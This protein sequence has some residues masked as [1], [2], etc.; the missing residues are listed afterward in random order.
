MDK[1][2]IQTALR[3]VLP[4]LPE[5][6][7]S[8]VA[9]HLVNDVGVVTTD[10]LKFVQPNDLPQLKPIQVRKLIQAWQ[11]E[12]MH[13]LVLSHFCLEYKNMKYSFQ[14]LMFDDNV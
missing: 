4:A 8:Q 14:R 6:E 7:A 10:D 3:A 13:F 5:D 2:C 1:E 11:K 9:E 12:G